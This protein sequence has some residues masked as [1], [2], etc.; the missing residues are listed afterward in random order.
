MNSLVKDCLDYTFFTLDPM[1]L[2]KCCYV[3]KAWNKMASEDR[4]W[5]RF[6]PQKFAK[7]DQKNYV[8]GHAVKSYEDIAARVDVSFNTISSSGK[9]F[10]HFS[11]NEDCYI[12]AELGIG[13]HPPYDRANPAIKE[14]CIFVKR[15]PEGDRK[16]CRSLLNDEYNGDIG[17]KYYLKKIAHLPFGIAGNF[18]FNQEIDKI[19]TSRLI[20]LKIKED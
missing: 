20:Y 8:A 2:V 17:E 18:G 13:N 10:C 12:F 1:D 7:A 5:K 4:F 3:S 6:V 9:F 19:L 11:L 16:I 15:L 14:I